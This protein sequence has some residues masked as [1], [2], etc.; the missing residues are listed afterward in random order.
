MR[1]IILILLLTTFQAKAQ[2]YLKVAD[3]LEFAK[4]SAWCS[5]RVSKQVEQFGKITLAKVNGQ[6]T[7][8]LGGSYTLE[9]TKIYWYALTTKTFTI[10]ENEKLI[11]IKIN[12]PVIRRKAS[13]KDFYTNWKTKNIP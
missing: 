3:K 1:T 11:S 6:Y 8:S 12:V 13:V 7:D 9:P 10:Q 5:V 4:Y 2:T